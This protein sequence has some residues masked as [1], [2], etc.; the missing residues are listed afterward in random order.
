LLPAALEN[1]HPRWRSPV[2]AVWVQ[3]VVGVVVS[4]GLGFKYGVLPAFIL[5][6]TIFTAVIVLIYIA[7]N[8]A[9]IVFYRRERP[10][11]FSFGK[12]LIVPL[13]GIAMFVPAWLT[14][15][16]IPA[17]KFIAELDYPFSLAGPIVAIWY[18]IGIVYM[19]Y[20]MANAR[21]RINDTGKVFIEEPVG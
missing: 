13:V 8:I 19:G 16:G 20:L 5:V 17:F 18:L 1:V 3:F 9:C 11:E 6:A 21:D 14:A 12:H 10:E 15:V 2:V 7:V 4:L